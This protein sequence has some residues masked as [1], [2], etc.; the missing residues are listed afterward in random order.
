MSNDLGIMLKVIH[1]QPSC[2]WH[3]L[4]HGGES[5][6]AGH[7]AGHITVL[8]AVGYRNWLALARL[9]Q[10]NGILG[11]AFDLYF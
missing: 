10:W 6:V 11:W 9:A 4:I 1:S 8:C 2:E 7:A 3:L 5:K